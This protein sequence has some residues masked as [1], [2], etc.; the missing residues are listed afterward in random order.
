V[1][2]ISV[3]SSF[4][5]EAVEVQTVAESNIC[6]VEPLPQT[7][8]SSPLIITETPPPQIKRHK[9]HEM[10]VNDDQEKVLFQFGE[11]THVNNNLTL[12]PSS[13]QEF[14]QEISARSKRVTRF[15]T[16]CRQHEEFLT[17]SL[18]IDDVM[19]ATTFVY[20]LRYD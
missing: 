8:L 18:C 9:H 1:N 5:K 12:A 7:Q 10:I 6:I 17:Q 14:C 2:L 15:L 13:F 11:E 19:I 4:Q 20:F 16:L 3:N